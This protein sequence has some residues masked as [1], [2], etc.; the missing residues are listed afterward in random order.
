MAYMDDFCCVHHGLTQEESYEQYASVLRVLEDLGLEDK[1]SKRQPPALRL[2]ILGFLVDTVGQTVTVTSARC[3]RLMAE[4]DAF[5]ADS[6]ADV[7]RRDLASLVGQLQWVAQIAQGGQLHL[8]QC[9]RARDDF[10]T[11]VGPSMREQWGRGV[12]VRRTAG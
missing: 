10:G 2:E 8:R 9:Y 6:G 7:G 11:E 12:R 1:A 3:E 5:L 4:I